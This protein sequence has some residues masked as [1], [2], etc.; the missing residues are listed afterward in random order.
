MKTNNP[1]YSFGLNFLKCIPPLLLLVSCSTYDPYED[2]VEIREEDTFVIGSDGNGFV[3]IM[4]GKY[5]TWFPVTDRFILKNTD[6][7]YEVGL[8]ELTPTR[9]GFLVDDVNFGFEHLAISA[10]ECFIAFTAQAGI[11][12]RDDLFIIDRS[13][14]MQRNITRQPDRLALYP[15]FLPQSHEVIFDEVIYADSAGHCIRERRGYSIINFIEN[16]YQQ[17]PNQQRYLGSLFI[18]PESETV[19][20]LQVYLSHDNTF[21]RLY[22]FSFSSEEVDSFLFAD[23]DI[24]NGFTLSA[25]RKV[26]F[27]SDDQS[28]KILDLV[29]GTVSQYYDG[30]VG[31]ILSFSP[32]FRKIISATDS[33]RV[34]NLITGLTEFTLPHPKGYIS[35]ASFSPSGAYIAY[36]TSFYEERY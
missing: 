31:N 13:T 9:I 15:Q 11:R 7:I 20:M 2:Y 19:V 6:G 12:H 16:T 25:D 18:N 1:F 35:S 22:D 8:P 23:L 4:S 27:S 5:P 3:R 30:P 10:D 28:I 21:S 33:A 14:M 34:L 32:D 17:L 24:R 26:Y 36:H 29:S